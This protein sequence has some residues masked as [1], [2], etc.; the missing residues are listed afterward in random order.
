[1]KGNFRKLTLL[2]AAARTASETGTA[3][4]IPPSATRLMVMLDITASATDAGDTLDV[5]IDISP[6]GGTT[7]IN[8]GHFTQ[9]AGNGAAARE[10]LTIDGQA[11]GASVVTVTA[12]AAA[13]AVRAGVWGSHVRARAAIADVSGDDASHTFSVVAFAA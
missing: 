12:D 1:M 11:P 4:A 6:D 3:T 7:W 5:Y 13:A 10:V 2:T 9:Q 8:A